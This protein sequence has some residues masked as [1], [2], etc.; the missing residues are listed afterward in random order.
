MR[1]CPKCGYVQVIRSIPQNKLYWDAYVKPM[2]EE[3]GSTPMEMHI[4]LR[5]EILGKMTCFAT[6]QGF[7][8]KKIGGTTTELT[9]KEFSD[10]LER[11]AQIASNIYGIEV[12]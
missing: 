11:V 12:G 6:K 5:D 10:Y 7:E 9:T 2:A 3:A 4:S 1:K 8:F